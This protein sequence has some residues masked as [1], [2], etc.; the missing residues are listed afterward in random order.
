MSRQSWKSLQSCRALRYRA[1]ICL[2]HSPPMRGR[3]ARQSRSLS[4]HLSELGSACMLR[5]PLALL[6]THRRCYVR[7]EKAVSE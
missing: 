4:R 2:L 3:A 6:Q 5:H 1:A 7:R